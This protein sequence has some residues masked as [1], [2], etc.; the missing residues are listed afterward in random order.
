MFTEIG[1]RARS[2]RPGR[3]PGLSAEGK[4]TRARLYAVA[5]QQIA[6]RGYERTTLRDIAAAA[7]VSVGLLYRYFPSK[8]AVVLA[9]YDE[10]SARFVRRAARQ[11][12]G[13]WRERF[14]AALRRSLAVLAPHRDTLAAL[15][16]I[17][18]GD[19]ADGL[20]APA[21]AGS[22]LRVQA[23]FEE[24]VT[25]ACD[26]PADAA[27]LGRVLYLAHLGV[28]LSWLLDQSPRQR[29]TRQW[30]RLLDGL[31]P[32]AALALAGPGPAALLR[33]A[34]EL[35]REGLFGEP[36]R[37]SRQARAPRRRRRR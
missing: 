23:V 28:I 8:R 14:A 2:R 30:L 12:P 25:G 11:Q 17:L 27:A 18:V 6:K 5:I 3:P 20:L 13:T 32:L 16:P 10:L 9:L 31:L 36:A 21:M 1:K 37:S 15:V 24:A 7:G 35:L 34:D 33:T 22:R 29:A 26:A 19:P 4:A